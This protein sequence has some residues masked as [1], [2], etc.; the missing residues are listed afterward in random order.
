M[1]QSLETEFP[2]GPPVSTVPALE[3]DMGDGMLS[4]EGLGNV[5]EGRINNL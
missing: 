4:Q 3:G 1:V 2:N 5:S